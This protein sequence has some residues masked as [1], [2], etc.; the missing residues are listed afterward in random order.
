MWFDVRS[1][2]SRLPIYLTNRP[3][4]SRSSASRLWLA[5]LTGFI[6]LA[7][8]TLALVR[9]SDAAQDRH[10]NAQK[11]HSHTL[12]VLISAE[13]IDTALNK[14]LRGER[15]YVLT[16]H[17]KS[18]VTFEQGLADYTKISGRLREL[19][20][21]NALQQHRLEELD[22]RARVFA[23]VS[24]HA[25]ELVRRGKHQ[26]AFAA[27]R[28]GGGRVALEN[29]SAMLDQIKAEE[30]RLLTIRDARNAAMADRSK[31]YGHVILWLTAALLI[32]IGGAVILMLRARSRADATACA[33]VESERL[34]RL[35]A[36]YSNDMIVRIG[37][38]GVRRYVSPA[39]RTLLGYTPDEMVG[40]APVAE[41]HAEDRARVVETCKTLLA[42]AANPICTYRQQHRDGHYVWLEASYQ[43]IRDEAGRPT[44]FVASVRDVSRRQAV[45][46]EAAE[47]SARLQESHRMFTMAS[48]LTHI[49]HWRVDLVRQEVVW[50]DEVYRL[51]G[52]GPE[53]VP[54]LESAID[55]YHPDDR[56]RVGAL[57]TRAVET[58]DS[59][60]FTAVLL[61]PDGDIR[62]VTSQGQAERAPDGSVIG[63]FG[64]IQDISEQVAAEAAVRKSEGMHRL[65]AEASSDIIVRF[66]LDGT[67]LYVS[68]A[69]YAVLGFE[70]DEMMTRGAVRDIHPDDR[71]LVLEAW[72]RVVRGETPEICLY[73]QRRHDGG[74]AWLEA[75]Y[76]LV[77]AEATGREP[78]IVA[79]VRDVTRRRLA[80]IA[81]SEAAARLQETNL[82]L[83]EA[84][85]RAES[86]GRTKSAFL[87]NISH[88]IRTPMNGVLGFTELVLSGELDPEQRRHV[89]L[90]AESGR[91]MMRLLNDIL[92]MSKIESGMMRVTEEP[93]DLRHVIRRCTDLMAPVAKAK[94]L[95]IS[96]K[97][98]PIVP[99][100]L[101]GDSLRLRQVLLNLIGTAVKF[102]TQG[103]VDVRARVENGRLWIDVLDTGIGIAAERLDSIF[104]QFTQADDST[105][106]VYGG[107]GLGLTI[108]GELAKLMGGSIAVQS[109]VGEGTTFTLE[110]PLVDAGASVAPGA[111]GACE[112]AS[113]SAGRQPR[114]LI[115]EDHD[116]NQT[117]IL[118]MARRAGMN[119][120]IASDGAV[121][122]AMVEE[123]AR[124]GRP[125]ELVLMDM[126]MPDV[127]GLQA[128]RR[129]R[130]LGHVAD[131]LPIVALTANA[132]AD[133]VQACLAAGM[134]DH[135]AKPVRVRDLMEVL[136]RFVRAGDRVLPVPGDA[137]PETTAPLIERYLARKAEALAAV[138]AIAGAG[139]CSDDEV[140]SL[141]GLLHRLAGIAGFFDDAQLGELARAIEKRLVSSS[142]QARMEIIRTGHEELRKA[143]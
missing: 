18:L 114:V 84:R 118:A 23:R 72:T 57:V 122:V 138:A 103:S 136:T 143:A 58:G 91:S 70:P 28:S 89:E 31:R 133:D 115:A 10:D 34:Y 43:L 17:P 68:P 95:A 139:R 52:V 110:L 24:R 119:P 59:F 12:S 94:G 15:G 65:L 69:C 78:E 36:D 27:L 48:A 5:C 82:M 76:R 137:P 140:S 8:L 81:T 127:D 129:L 132:Y 93:V 142:A 35:L 134:Q 45:E 106:R 112:T 74:E 25:V 46:L 100:R 53:F 116:I 90:I 96:V 41:I 105:A 131:R 102:T 22:A 60:E 16:A 75:A 37:L 62:H 38:D 7:V 85:E 21:D 2:G 111:D 11:W 32:M 14:A 130:A 113:S 1:S 66:A 117:L 67:P 64:V 77:D 80:E 86:A 44:E 107:S 87:A 123:A 29:A 40:G 104:Q 83:V 109:A 30:R 13:Q 61:R 9:N 42:G 97:V 26:E 101:F 47:T 124:S 73:R 108:S 63:I 49:G 92:D 33:A 79:T 4:T 88:E 20:R 55:F 120:E 6:A 135:L 54:T 128:T 99:A 3:D 141:A 39:C 56:E 125:F 98:E 126:Q 51:H 71:T 50:S 19:T 121:A